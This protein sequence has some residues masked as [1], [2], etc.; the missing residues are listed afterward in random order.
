VSEALPGSASVLILGTAEWDA[1]IATNQHYVAR[2]LARV[3]DVAFVESLGLRRPKLTRADLTRMLS[4]ARRSFGATSV[5][6]RRPKPDTVH[7]VS[8][9]V[10]PVHRA[11]TRLVNRTLLRRATAGWLASR[12]PRVLWTFTP[13]TY[14]LEAAADIA[15]YHCVDLL[16][17]FPG[18]DGK[19]VARGERHLSQRVSV[20]IATS[21]A[22]RDHLVGAGFPRVILLPNVAD[23]STFSAASRPSS[24]RRPAV[25]FA[26]NLSPHKLDVALLEAIAKTVQGRAELLLAGPMAA[27][28]GDFG[29]AM[30]RLRDLGATYLGLLTLPE[31]ADVAGRC[32][33][34]LIPYAL[35]DYTRGVSPLKCFEYLASGL[36]VVGT[37]L[38][39]VEQLAATNPHVSALDAADI[40]AQVLR[41][42]EPAT[43]GEIGSR[44]G[45]AADSG[46]D[47]RGRVLRDLLAAELLARSAR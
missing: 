6:A 9:L 18:I 10:V 29:P 28:G 31:L 24:E 21:S 32:T 41:I 40:P 1:P 39:E 37:R 22:V 35:N 38:P 8:P 2:E 7:I 23:V 12:R 17:T 16:A 4:R 33:V 46:W 20:A 5:P 43:N 11:P 3:S 14:G 44:V 26:G 47:A 45:A 30:Q 34:G 15:V 19:A 36:R 42:V 25:L 27:G 13:V